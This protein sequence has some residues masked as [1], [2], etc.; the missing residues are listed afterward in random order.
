MGTSMTEDRDHI[1]VN[2]GKFEHQP[3]IH[4]HPRIGHR[5]KKH[6]IEGI[7]F[8]WREV[9][10]DD[11]NPQGCLLAHEMGLGKT[12]QVWVASDLFPT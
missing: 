12:M 9:V 7:Q 10:R 6:Q 4:L 3:A 5:A 8:M 11:Q 1:I 2:I